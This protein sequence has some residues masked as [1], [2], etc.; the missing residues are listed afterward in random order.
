MSYS[1]TKKQRV[2]IARALRAAK[3]YLWDGHG[4]FVPYGRCMYICDA[5][6]ATSKQEIAD[7]TKAMISER[8]GYEFSLES[9]LV[10]LG[11]AAS[12]QVVQPY[13]QAHRLAWLDQLIEEFSK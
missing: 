2:G 12:K 11:G 8:L 13:L 9:W 1:K 6:R 5:V 7:L 4:D 10:N 3:P